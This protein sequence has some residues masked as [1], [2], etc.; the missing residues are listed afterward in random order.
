MSRFFFRNMH[1]DS[2]LYM[3]RSAA[4]CKLHV[5]RDRL[6]NKITLKYQQQSSRN[7]VTTINQCYILILAREP[8]PQ[9]L[10]NLHSDAVKGCDISM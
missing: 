3:D 8:N 2:S 1:P 5:F 4:G 6:Q 10:V 9:F 7:S